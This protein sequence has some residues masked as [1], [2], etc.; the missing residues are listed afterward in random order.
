MA[1]K[2]Q[3]A[4]QT[5]SPQ[6]DPEAKETSDIFS[7]VANLRIP[8]NLAADTG[9]RKALLHISVRRPDRQW[10]IRVHPAAE[11]RVDVGVIE[12]KEENETYLVLPQ[13]CANLP[14]E[15]VYKTLYTAINRQG[16]VFLWPARLPDVDGR[17]D[18]WNLTAR[19]AAEMAI[20]RWHRIAANRSAGCYDVYEAKGELVD[21][22]WPEEPFNKLLE[23]AF[24]G[25]VISDTDHPVIRQLLGQA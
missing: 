25:R 16:V 22:I 5:E 20:K 1:K 9:I 15:V 8:S 2:P 6:T 24:R 18:A 17:L 21:P 7:D 4:I 19:E 10:F 11:Y 12:L 23:V 14:G 3:D 13:L